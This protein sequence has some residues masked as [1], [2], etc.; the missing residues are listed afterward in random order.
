MSKKLRIHLGRQTIQNGRPSC[1]EL[2]GEGVAAALPD[3]FLF[4]LLHLDAG[5]ARLLSPDVTAPGTSWG[6]G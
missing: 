2:Q 6:A 3:S 4:S 5:G 1:A